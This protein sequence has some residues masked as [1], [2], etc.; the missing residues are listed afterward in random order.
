VEGV[1]KRRIPDTIR[2]T[3]VAEATENGTGGCACCRIAAPPSALPNIQNMQLAT[4][5]TLYSN[6][7][8]P[9]MAESLY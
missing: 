2:S 1:E 7:L 4:I 6:W 5:N 9:P 8:L 3:R